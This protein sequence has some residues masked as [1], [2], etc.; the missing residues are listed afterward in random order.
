MQRL[1]HLIFSLSLLLLGACSQEEEG[2]YTGRME[3]YSLERMS[4][5]DFQGVATV[6]ELR[7]GGIEV[8]VQLTGPSTDAI[9]YYPAHLHYG[10]YLDFEAPMAQMLN[11]VDARVLLSITSINSLADGTSMNFDD[12]LNFEGHIKIHLAEDG[13]DYQIILASGNVGKTR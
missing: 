9:Y 10:E 2:I 3:A 13:P 1:F 12:F 7:K 6:R 5:F 11:P 8:E 4:D